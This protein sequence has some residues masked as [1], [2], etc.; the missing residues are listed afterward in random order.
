MSTDRFLKLKYKTFS[1]HDVVSLITRRPNNVSTSPSGNHPSNQ[2][3]TFLAIG[4]ASHNSISLKNIQSDSKRSIMRFSITPLIL[5]PA[6]VYSQS[7]APSPS[8]TSPTTTPTPTPNLELRQAVAPAPVPVAPAPVGGAPVGGAA[9]P[10]NPAVAPQAVNP[11]PAAA[12]PAAPAA[13][14]PVTTPAMQANPVTTIMQNT[15]VGG[16]SK[17]VPV[18]FTQTFAGSLTSVDAVQSGSVGMGSL[19]GSVGVV[20]SSAAMAGRRGMGG[21]EGWGGMVAAVA[22]GT[23]VGWVRVVGF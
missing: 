13:G 1:N 14:Q 7:T 4:K 8:T 23:L 2:K 10:V 12:N 5:L 20:K 11:A 19:T 3:R 6:L 21:M 9:A 15:V 17:Q 18:V 22:A 16:V